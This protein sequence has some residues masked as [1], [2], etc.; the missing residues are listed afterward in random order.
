MSSVPATAVAAITV[1]IIFRMPPSPAQR[2]ETRES[3]GPGRGGRAGN[4]RLR[5]LSPV[6]SGFAALALL[7]GCSGPG[8]STNESA[9]D[10]AT[11]QNGVESA[12]SNQ[13]MTD[14]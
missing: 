7:A 12:A 5:C 8:T 14:D 13:S 2:A 10:L 1:R 3:A 4:R 11:L 9:D 6:E